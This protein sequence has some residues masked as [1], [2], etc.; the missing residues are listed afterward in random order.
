MKYLEEENKNL[1]SL[2]SSLLTAVLVLTGGIFWL[3]T[4]DFSRFIKIICTIEGA[5]LDFLL[6]TDMIS[7][8]EKI[9]KN[10]GVM[11]KWT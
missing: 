7:A 4:S 1:I 3:Y 8:N 2:R 9:K 10:I 5:Y 11:K 6:V